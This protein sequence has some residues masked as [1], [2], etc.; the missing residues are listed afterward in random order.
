MSVIRYR[1]EVDGLRALAVLPVVLFHLELLWLP[2]GFIGVD[3]FFVISG[4]LITSIIL[5][6]QAAGT[7]TFSSFWMRRVR[8]ILPAML[9]MLIVTSVAGY[10]LMYGPSW[11]GIGDQILSAIFLYANLEMWQLADDYWGPAAETAPLLHTWSLSVEEQF[12]LFYPL[13]LLTLLKLTPRRVFTLILAGSIVSFS[14]GVYAT[15]HSPSAAFYFSPARAWELSAGCLL[16]I[17][18]LSRGPAPSGNISRILAFTG[19]SLIGAGYYLIEGSDDFPGFLAL[20]P[21]VGTVLVI[22]FSNSDKCFAGALLSW[23]PVVYIGKCSYS[24]YLWHWP[25]IVFAGA[26]EMRYPEY[27]NFGLV[28]AIV[29]LLSLTSYHFIEKPTRKMKRVL[30]PIIGA[31]IVSVTCAVFL[32]RA[33]YEYDLSVFVPTEA[34]FSEY[35]VAPFS[36]DNSSEDVY[37]T[38]GIIKGFGDGDPTIVVL[39]D[40][41]GLMWGRTVEEICQELEVTVSFYTAKATPLWI[42]LPVAEKPSRYFTKE[43]KFTFDSKRLEYIKAWSPE[44]VILVDR[45]SSRGDPFQYVEFLR[46]LN[47]CGSEVILVGQPPEIPTVGMNV[48]VYVA[49]AYSETEAGEGKQ[50]SMEAYRKI[51]IDAANAKIEELAGMLDFC[52]YLPVND[53]F[54]LPEHRVLVRDGREILYFDDDHLSYAGAQRAKERIKQKIAQ[55]ILV[56]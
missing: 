49:Y 52:H 3:V 54:E 9:A 10:F 21:V 14:I 36:N 16:A 46:Y 31:L 23:P 24:L 32:K 33:E 29:A 8:R 25:V 19:L 38:G 51:E 34:F 42:E 4:F 53:L 7:F 17:F 55:I 11:V 43:Q 40:S 22:R 13:L 6:E 2:G 37:G 12:Y 41:H 28:I 39:G 47:S 1:P 44:V 45:W 20:L 26:L 27:I 5:K 15:Y 48:P 35:D 56:E 18:E 50:F 30:P